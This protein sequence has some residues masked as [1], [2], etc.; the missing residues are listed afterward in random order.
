MFRAVGQ[1]P[2]LA[3]LVAAVGISFSGIL[4]RLSHVSSSTG[5]FY[6]CVWALPPLFV[7]ARIE[8]RRYGKRERHARYA[9]VARRRVLRRGSDPLAQRDRAGRRRARDGPR[10]RAGRARR[11]ARVGSA[12]RAAATLVA[13]GDSHRRFRRR[14]HLG[15]AR[16]G[17]VRIESAARRGLRRADRHRV[18][19]LSARPATEQQGSAPACRAAFHRD[20][21]FGDLLRGD[22]SRHRRP[23]SDALPVGDRLARRARP[24]LAGRSGGC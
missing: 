22:R 8:D 20:V 14:P 24:L 15:C 18:R 23:R 10:Q 17:R 19:G 21:V 2:V 3:V 1:R 12:R 13:R 7:L 6:R 5:A 4:F 11:P 16:T 9:G